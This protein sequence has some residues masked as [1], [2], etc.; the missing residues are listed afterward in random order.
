MHTTFN[1]IHLNNYKLL[2]FVH[3]AT[4]F[5]ICSSQTMNSNCSDKVTSANKE[6]AMFKLGQFIPGSLREDGDIDQIC[7]FNH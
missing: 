6:P 5:V 7:S 1:M 4:D 3:F 2:S